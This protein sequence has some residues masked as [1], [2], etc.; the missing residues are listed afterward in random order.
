MTKP[1]HKA[2]SDFGKAADRFIYW[3]LIPAQAFLLVAKLADSHV[4]SWW[5]ALIPLLILTLPLLLIGFGVG[6]AARSKK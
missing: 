3:V 5:V 6:M 1:R 4:Y 2:Q